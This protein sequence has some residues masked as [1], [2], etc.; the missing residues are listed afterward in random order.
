MSK[1]QRFASPGRLWCGRA[2]G[3][4]AGAKAAGLVGALALAGA[5]QADPSS[6]PEFAWTTTVKQSAALRMKGADPRLTTGGSSA[7]QDDGD[8]NFKTGLVSSRTDILSEL[9]VKFTGYGLRL[10]GAGWYDSAYRRGN[11]NDS[12]GTSQGPGHSFATDTAKLHGEKAELLDAFAYASF[13]LG[14][15]VNAKL[16]RHALVYGESLFYGINGI[17]YGMVP[18][19]VIKATSVP[20]TQFKE[21]IRPVNQVSAQMS[22]D[23]SVSLGAYYQFRW[24][25]N[26]LPAAG[27]YLSSADMLDVGGSQLQMIPPIPFVTPGWSA[28]R[29]EDVKPGNGGAGGIQLRVT[30]DSIGTDFGLYAIRYHERLPNLVLTDARPTSFPP[31]LPPFLPSQYHLEFGK[32]VRA[33]GGSFST[34][35][36]SASVAGEM[37]IRDGAYLTSDP[38]AAYAGVQ[39]AR[40]R[41]LHVNLSTLASFGRS[42]VS[43][44]ATLAAE[45]ACNRVL[46][47]TNGQPLAAN[48]TR[49]ACAVRA[50]YEPK[51]RQVLS[52][53]DLSVPITVGYTRGRSAAVP[54]F[55]VDKGGDLGVAL[56]F[57]YLDAWRVGV[58]YTTFYGPVG[59]NLD[60][61][62]QSFT[63][64]QSLADRDFVWLSFATTF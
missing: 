55:G 58:G 15:P 50:V 47:V 49:S 14:R 26:R 42:F 16:G 13:D 63:F 29:T 36:E 53:L 27:S 18:V 6:G 39:A 41:S 40:G 44:E 11:N 17:A 3:H 48:S 38:V 8:R 46:S 33:Y 12:P 5:A 30:A 61:T 9:D 60:A 52:G 62:G 59:T 32:G 51:Y 7:A 21:L 43:N 22:I 24:E 10:S 37:S 20:G 35:F 57:T 25:R 23:P 4:G 56:N 19:D 64:R 28:S 1:A 34:A 45:L 2:L 54:F 31:F